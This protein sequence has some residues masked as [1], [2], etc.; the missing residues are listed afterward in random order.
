MPKFKSKGREQ[1]E[2]LKYTFGYSELR[3]A[4]FKRDDFR[5]FWCNTTCRPPGMGK[6]T[7]ATATVDHLI[8][9]AKGGSNEFSNLVTACRRCNE[10]RGHLDP[11]QSLV[12]L[13][14]KREAS[15]A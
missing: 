13:K 15:H 4:L 5:C 6:P 10:L 12:L 2:K 1:R 3:A 8:P 14:E 9:V 7:D 11:I